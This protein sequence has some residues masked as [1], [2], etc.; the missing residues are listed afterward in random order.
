MRGEGSFWGIDSE[1]CWAA[2]GGLFLS[3]LFLV[4]LVIFFS[5]FGRIRLDPCHLS[6]T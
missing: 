1:G 4:I 3:F 6:D 2:Y 5:F